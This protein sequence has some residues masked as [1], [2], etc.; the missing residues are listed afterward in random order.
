M[1]PVGYGCRIMPLR[2]GFVS[3]CYGPRMIDFVNRPTLRQFLQWRME[4]TH[5]SHL[6]NSSS[7]LF[8]RCGSLP[9]RNF[10]PHSS[11]R[12]KS[13]ADCCRMLAGRVFL[14]LTGVFAIAGTSSHPRGIWRTTVPRRAEI[15]QPESSAFESASVAIGG[16]PN[17]ISY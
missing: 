12:L 6:R 4:C 11:K 2:P 14:Q 1:G 16:K 13:S 9:Q 10:A 3:W 15:V 7:L 5:S 8:S 17:D